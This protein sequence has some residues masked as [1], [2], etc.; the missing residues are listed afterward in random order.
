MYEVARALYRSGA[1]VAYGGHLRNEG[2]TAASLQHL[3]D[4]QQSAIE[5]QRIQSYVAWPLHCP[6]AA[7]QD[8]LQD[9]F[10]KFADILELAAPDDFGG[11]KHEFLDSTPIPNR[12][13]W[14]RS[15]TAMRRKMNS[16]IHARVVMGG[17]L[18]G[19][20]GRYPGVVEEALFAV[21]TRTPL[22]ICG[23]FGGAAWALAQ[24]FQGKTVPALELSSQYADE[25][26]AASASYYENAI[27]SKLRENLSRMTPYDRFVGYS[28]DCLLL[29][30]FF[31]EVGVGGLSNGLS[32]R[33]NEILFETPSLDEIRTLVLSGL[34][35]LFR[36]SRDH[37]SCFGEVRTS[38]DGEFMR[39]IRGAGRPRSPLID[40]QGIALIPADE[41]LTIE[42][43]L[44]AVL[45]NGYPDA[46]QSALPQCASAILEQFGS[47]SNARS[48]LSL[49]LAALNWSPA[50]GDASVIAEFLAELYM[51]HPAIVERDAVR[52]RLP[53]A[54]IS[55]QQRNASFEE[56]NM[57]AWFEDLPLD[58]T[59]TEVKDT[60]KL[61]VAGYSTNP[62]ALTLAQDA[63]LDL[64]RLNQMAPVKFLM[65]DILDKAR[66]SDRLTLLLAEVL[67][68]PGQEAIHGELRSLIAGYEGTIAAAAMRRKPSISTLATLPSSIEVLGVGKT[69]P[70]P[71]ATPGLEKLINAAAGFADPA[72]FRLRLAEAEVRTARI[73]IGGKPKGSGFLIGDS[74]LLTN[75]HVVKGKVEGAVAVFDNKVSPTGKGEQD[76]G[77]AVAFATDWLVARSVHDLPAVELGP[78][79]PPQGNWDFAVVRLAEPV[80]TQAI[81]PDPKDKDADKRGCYLLNGNPYHF[82]EAEPILILG[83]PSGRPVQFSYAS[84]SGVK[85]TENL[86]RVRY[87]TNTEGGSSGS[88]VFNREW[89]VVALH[90]GAGPTS[91]P[92]EFNLRTGDFNQGI[93][94]SGIVTELKKQ[95]DGRPELAEL[96]LA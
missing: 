80:G 96:G 58:W 85:P 88:P 67:R 75:W 24:L 41:L 40:L 1:S 59:R 36:A 64:T 83:H 15:L 53:S 77:R 11:P 47:I 5:S 8:R 49:D 19:F 65:R 14:F 54:L 82:D 26:Y 46:R 90:H 13:Y 34:T 22:Y 56:V 39:S 79:G 89:R 81:G 9:D 3:I 71:M 32:R 76:A 48:L 37:E 57:K 69:T 78:N 42:S 50:R 60:E 61:L 33:E 72:K 28:V 17:K 87:G 30:E 20:V 6:A 91:T 62:A 21:A 25:Q 35:R 93:P 68:D 84:P 43:E 27:A 86:N 31:R 94:I 70:Q 95:L 4:E 18:H 23:G 29:C 66:Q 10:L 2:F 16:E 51:A 38:P 92:G 44:F 74:L 12:Y 7:S 45:G 63:G 55:V 52:R 73:D